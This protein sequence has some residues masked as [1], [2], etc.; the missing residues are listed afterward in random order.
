MG[1]TNTFVGADELCVSGALVRVNTGTVFAMRRRTRFQCRA[2][3]EKFG[4]ANGRGTLLGV[5][6]TI[7]AGPSG[8]SV[9]RCSKGLRVIYSS[10]PSSGESR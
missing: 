2:G 7:T 1:S 4:N 3:G 5:G 10:R 8:G 9:V 6:G